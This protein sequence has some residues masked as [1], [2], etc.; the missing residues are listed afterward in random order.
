MKFLNGIR[1]G[2]Y[3]LE[4]D[5]VLDEIREKCVEGRKNYTAIAVYRDEEIEPEKFIEWAKY[6]AENDIYFHFACSRNM[7]FRVPFTAET[8]AEMRRV[9]GE[10]FLGVFVPELGNIYGCSGYGYTKKNY[11]HNIS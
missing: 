5:K 7:K 2:E 6:M 1:I 10:H 3:A 8:A 11:H 9:A 4:P